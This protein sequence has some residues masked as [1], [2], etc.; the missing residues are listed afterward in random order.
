MFLFQPLLVDSQSL[1]VPMLEV[2][3]VMVVLKNGAVIKL[4][5]ALNPF[6]RDSY[7]GVGRVRSLFTSGIVDVDVDVGHLRHVIHIVVG[8]GTGS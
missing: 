6:P 7:R 5:A 8:H 4:V 1:P 3:E 2:P